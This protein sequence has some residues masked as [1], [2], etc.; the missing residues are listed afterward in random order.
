MPADV[1]VIG[2]GVV[3]CACAL[4][5]ARRGA[6]VTLLEAGPALAL[7]ASGTNSGILHT[8]FDSIPGELETELILRAARLRDPVLAALGVPVVSCGAR[9]SPLEPGQ[10]EAI[11]ALA[12]NAGRN[13]VDARLGPDGSLAVPGEAVTDP[14]AFTLALAAAAGSLGGELRTGFRVAA[15]DRRGPGLELCD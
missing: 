2:G 9:M 15:I 1:I 5:L 11:A 13:G 3:G 14:V 8:G 12:E 7:Q 4:A 6:A 10:R